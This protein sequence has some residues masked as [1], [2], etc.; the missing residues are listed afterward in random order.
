MRKE[1]QTLALA[2]YRRFGGMIPRSVRNYAYRVLYPSGTQKPMMMYID[3]VGNCNLRCPSCPSGNMNMASGAPPMDP[4]LF[5]SIIRKGKEEYGVF[6]VGLFNWTEPLLHPQLPELIRIV[7]QEG[8]LCGLSSNLNVMRN[9]DEIL[10]AGP[11]D[12]RISLSGFTQAVYG[13]THVRGDIDKV[14]QN[15]KLLSEARKRHRR[16]K[17]V[18]YVYFHKYLNNLHEIE[19][20]RQYASSLGFDWLETWAYY[21][22][23]ERVFD[24]LEGTLPSDQQRFVRE[25]FALPVMDALAEAK[26]FKDEPCSLLDNQLVIDAR[27]N[28]NMCCAVYDTEKNRLGTFMDMT[29]EDM[30]HAKFRHSTCNRCKAFGLHAYFTYT[31]NAALLKKYNNLA[32]ANVKKA[33]SAT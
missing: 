13:R 8:L 11:D 30:R 19:P 23:L 31:E 17:T 16:C 7:K 2:T 29:P 5:A 1:I 32:V 9:A 18:V 12:L 24:L 20:M 4:E 10:D 22:P 33:G 26:Q 6:F 27:G 14:K 15:M 3:V 28:V 25:E 21:M